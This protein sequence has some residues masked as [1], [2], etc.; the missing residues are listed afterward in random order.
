MK[1]ITLFKRNNGVYYICDRTTKK[2]NNTSTGTKNKY[3]AGLILNDYIKNEGSKKVNISL[4]DFIKIFFDVS[5]GNRN[6]GTIQNYQ[7]TFNIFLKTNANKELRKYT[8]LEFDKFF[9]LRKIETSVLTA[10]RD[11]RN[12]NALFNQ[13]VKYRY[14]DKNIIPD[15]I[16][17]KLPE[18][19]IKNF[20]KESFSKLISIIDV[21]LYRDVFIFAVLSGLRMSEIINLKY[22]HINLENKIINVFSNSEHITKDKES[23]QVELNDLLI[24]VIKKYESDTFLF[25]GNRDKEKLNRKFLTKTTKKYCKRAGL[26]EMNFKCFRSTFG[27]WLL[28]AGVNLKYISQQ[29]GHS[30]IQTTE[31]HYA[32][33][34]ISESKG[35]VNKITV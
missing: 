35:W 16:K 25:V 3:D 4:T 2:Q 15:T 20:T 34:I 14:L 21:E 30:S 7:S 10:D 5:S 12:F 22:E 33:Y 24:P 23:R 27:K 29:L 8:V 18:P 28:D 19:E 32:K 31:K 26:P 13:A 6:Y 1:K 11:R 17:F 9:S